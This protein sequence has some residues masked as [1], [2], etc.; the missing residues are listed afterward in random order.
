MTDKELIAKIRELKQIKPN[1]NWA[2][3]LRTQ[4][5][6]NEPDKASFINELKWGFGLIF[7]YKKSFAT[8]SVLGLFLAIFGLSL[9][10]LPG[11]LLYPA[12]KIAER[13]QTFFVADKNQS[14]M[15]FDTA[16]KRLD[17]LSKAVQANSARNL[18]PAISEYKASVAQV[19]KSLASETQKRS[20]KSVKEIAQEIKQLTEKEQKVEAFGINIGEN[21]E[22]NNALSQLVLQEINNLET[23][24]LTVEQ[25]E[26]LK[27]AKAEFDAK[28]Y[29]ESLEQI[30][31]LN[32]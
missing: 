17:E 5:V 30:L 2:F 24:T 25:Q 20:T 7:Q 4:I 27:T 9:N 6:G 15:V 11:D 14:K 1:Q 16:N 10:A 22:L 28:N 12:K 26:V 29:S 13:Y 19:V 21:K 3:S 18:A 23:R 32:P 31:L 8:V